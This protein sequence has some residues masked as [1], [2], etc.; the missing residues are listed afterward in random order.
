RFSRSRIRGSD[1]LVHVRFGDDPSTCTSLKKI[2][3]G[4]C[5]ASISLPFPTAL[6]GSWLVDRRAMPSAD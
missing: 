1:R 2:S 5:R 4:P 3:M 6:F